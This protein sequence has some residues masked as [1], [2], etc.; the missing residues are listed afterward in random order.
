VRSRFPQAR[1]IEQ[2]NAGMGAGNNAGMRVASGR[3]YLLLN[4][5]A[6]LL[7]GA[8]ERLV[9]FADEHPD[10]AIVA[11]RLRN[12]DGSLQRSVRAFPTR[13]RLA[14]EYFFLRKLAP[15]SRLLNP[16]Y[17]GWFDHET[18]LDADWISGAC[19]L[20]RRAAAEQVG[21]FDE[22]FFMFSEE[23]DW[24]YRFH[25]AGWRVLF[26]PGA[27][28]AHV[29]GATHGG[30]LYRENLRGHLR[31]FA[32]HHGPREAERVRRMLLLALRLRALLLRGE[33]SRRYAEAA[34]WLASASAE[35]LLEA[36]D[37]RRGQ[38]V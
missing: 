16:L 32:K 17:A 6:W 21:L 13:W 5:D 10:A 4:S 35:R 20:V 36:C 24:C 29:G 38:S 2:E 26:Y 3:Y 14:T 7:P 27:E 22:R 15:R 37:Q 18:V 8:I 11:P 30:E 1:V 12:P 25:A 19:L 23:T 33:P 31:F 9:A 28:A 34:R